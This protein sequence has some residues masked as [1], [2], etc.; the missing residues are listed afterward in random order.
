MPMLTPEFPAG[1]PVFCNYSNNLILPDELLGVKFMPCEK[2]RFIGNS[3]FAF[4]LY[5]ES[6]QTKH[7]G[8]FLKIAVISGFYCLSSFC[9][10]SLNRLFCSS[11]KRMNLLIQV[12]IRITIPIVITK[13]IKT[14]T[15]VISKPIILIVKINTI[16]CFSLINCKRLKHCHA[17]CT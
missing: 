10:I 8:S 13:E 3:C 15:I 5:W 2:N 11:F 6:F 4:I 14:G 17:G 12:M 16:K 7:P 1:F 9:M